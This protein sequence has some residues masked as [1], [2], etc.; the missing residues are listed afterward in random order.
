MTHIQKF[1]TVLFTLAALVP[2]LAAAQNSSDDL[3]N[4][5]QASVIADPRVANIPPAQLQGLIDAL[6]VEANAQHM[7]SADILWK[8]QQQAAAAT[9]SPGSQTPGVVCASGWQGYLCQFN[10]IFGF[11]GS[12]YEIP[13]FI[14]ITSAFLLAVIWELIVHHRKKMAQKAGRPLVR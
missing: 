12:N 10:Q 14:L 6:V 7:S 2:A 11:E 1:L 5:I 3:R 13:I 8:P 9:F 4:T